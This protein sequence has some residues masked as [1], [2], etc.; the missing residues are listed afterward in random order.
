MLRHIPHVA[1]M[2]RPELN[3]EIQEAR[4]T[5]G[6]YLFAC[7]FYGITPTF[8]SPPATGSFTVPFASSFEN[9][10]SLSITCAKCLTKGF[11]NAAI[12][13]E[14][15]S[16]SLLIVDRLVG[17]LGCT[18]ALSWNPGKWLSVVLENLENGVSLQII[19]WFVALIAGHLVR[20]FYDG[21]Q[22]SLSD[23]CLA[24]NQRL[25]A[26]YFY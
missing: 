2:Q 16:Q 4:K 3:G 14:V 9:L 13:R 19:R 18:V 7:T 8:E 23:C 17:R 5:Q 26:D 1:L 15:F 6:P 20:Q 22:D 10:I 24:S 21:R 12:L 25:G 11:G